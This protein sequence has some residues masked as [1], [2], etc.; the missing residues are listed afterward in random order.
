M[1]ERKD[2]EDARAGIADTLASIDRGDLDAS[3][4]QRAFLAGAIA[5]LDPKAGDREKSKD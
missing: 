1:V 2:A 4:E 3:P 5:A